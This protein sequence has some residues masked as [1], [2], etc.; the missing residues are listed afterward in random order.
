MS[1]EPLKGLKPLNSRCICLH[2]TN[3]YTNRSGSRG[4]Q[5]LDQL[6]RPTEPGQVGSGSGGFRTRW[7]QGQ[8]GSGPGGPRMRSGRSSA[9]WVFL[10]MIF[11]LFCYHMTSRRQNKAVTYLNGVFLKKKKKIPYFNQLNSSFLFIGSRRRHTIKRH[12]CL[13]KDFYG[14]NALILYLLIFSA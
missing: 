12:D 3:N 7:V 6:S 1:S 8:V 9:R 4:T 2:A 14:L 10:I 5:E 13:K 11:C